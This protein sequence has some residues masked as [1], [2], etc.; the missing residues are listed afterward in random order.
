[1]SG[2]GG[3]GYV[4]GGDGGRSGGGGS[5]DC[6]IVE[7]VPLNS[8][9]KAVLAT[10]KVGQDLDVVLVNKSLVAR[11][12][13]G[14][15]AGSLTPRSLARLIACIE[16]GNEYLAAVVKVVGGACEVEIRRK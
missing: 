13:A 1:M 6:D 16:E 9:K 3:G 15:D 14:H 10:L 8:P 11:D 2:G 7:K 12:K 5:D 4:G